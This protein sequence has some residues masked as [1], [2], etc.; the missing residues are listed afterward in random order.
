M[1]KNYFQGTK[2]NPFHISVGAI[3]VNKNQQICCHYFKKIKDMYTGDVM[4]DFYIL[5]RE[6][7]V[8]NET[9]ENAL[10]R[11][12]N[13][14]FAIKA[15]I[16]RYLGSIVSSYKINNVSIEKTTLYFLCNLI[17]RKKKRNPNDQEAN[18]EIKWLNIDKLI[19][20]MQ[21]QRKKI[22]RSD[23]DE[24]KILIRAKKYLKL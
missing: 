11:G 13:E 1:S 17:H 6:T 23:N 20:K 21:E 22:K 8:P 5:M 18:S 9:I 3:T 15:K 12:L 10:S 4:E 24:S 16:N 14:E 19:Q 2:N 7:I